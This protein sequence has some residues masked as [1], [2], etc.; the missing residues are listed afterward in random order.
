MSLVFLYLISLFCS[1]RV[2]ITFS[3]DISS[4]SFCQGQFLTL[5]LFFMILIVFR[6]LVMYFV[7]C[8]SFGMSDAFLIIRLELMFF[9]GKDQG[10]KV[11]F[12]SYHFKGTWYQHDLSTVDVNL[13]LLAEVVFYCVSPL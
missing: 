4:G 1:S 8:S 6:V 11:Q 12:S 13:G 5:P 9:L 10:S 2:H 7:K 3:C